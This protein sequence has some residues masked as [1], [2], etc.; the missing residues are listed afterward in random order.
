MTFLKLPVDFHRELPIGGIVLNVAP[1]Q[2][3][4]E[5]QKI[6]SVLFVQVFSLSGPGTP[7]KRHFF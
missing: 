4:K 7:I 3:G 5:G 1:G 6:A 2:G